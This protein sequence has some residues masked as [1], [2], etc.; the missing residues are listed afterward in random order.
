[1]T[2]PETPL[3]KAQKAKFKSFI[4]RRKNHEPLAY[5]LG[6]KEFYGLDFK[7][8]KSTLV[9]RPE[10]EMIVELVTQNVERKPKERFVIIDIGTGSGNII[11]SIAKNLSRYALRD[12]RY[13]FYGL[14][15]SQKALRVAKHN[16]KKNKVDKKIEFI[17]GNL[18]EPIIKNI[19]HRRTRL[20]REKVIFVANLPYL[21]KHWKNLLKSSDSAGLKFEPSSALYGGSD[22]LDLYRK[23]SKQILQLKNKGILIDFKL[24]CETG[25]LHKNEMKKIFFYAKIFTYKKD[26]GG[27]WRIAVMDI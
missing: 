24:F 27:K 25:H 5:I 17:K 1:M 23:L 4:N 9:P 15:I 20:W 11:I 22:G 8:D 14:D 21:D 2:H 7:V 3:N 12:T 16:A 26:L 10:T 13:A 18:L 6:H 19:R